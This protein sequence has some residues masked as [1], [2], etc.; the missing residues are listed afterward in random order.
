MIESQSGPRPSAR[1]LT[2]LSRISKLHGLDRGLSES[3]SLVGER[4]TSPISQEPDPSKDVGAVKCSQGEKSAEFASGSDSQ[5]E[6]KD[7]VGGVDASAKNVQSILSR[8][9]PR[10]FP[11]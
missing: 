6:Q 1:F 5:H 3:S 9:A 7:L 8:D 4:Q 11:A 10:V 2:E